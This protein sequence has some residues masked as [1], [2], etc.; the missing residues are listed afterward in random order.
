MLEHPLLYFT[1]QSVRSATSVTDSTAATDNTQ[2]VQRLNSLVNWHFSDFRSHRWIRRSKDLVFSPGV[3]RAYPGASPPFVDVPVALGWEVVMEHGTEATQ[4][5][6]VDELSCSFP[7]KVRI[8]QVI[9]LV[10]LVQ[11]GCELF[12]RRK[13]VHVDVGVLWSAFRVVFG[14]STHDDGQDVSPEIQN[15]IIECHS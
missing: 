8:V 12:G 15:H 4:E 2:V 13:F 14:V 11:V 5:V 7:T 9:I 6:S 1:I 10:Q 3:L